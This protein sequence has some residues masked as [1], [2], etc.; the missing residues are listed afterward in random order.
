VVQPLLAATVLSMVLS[1]VLIRH[2]RRITRAL[3]GESGPPQS[4]AMR[5]TRAA[6]AV[7]GRDHVVICGFGRVG[8]NIARVLETTGF[9]FIALE[10]DAYRIRAGRQAGDPVIY[11]DAGE[12]KVLENVGVAHASCVVITFASPE[13]ALRILRAVRELRKDVPERPKWCP[14]PSRPASCC[15]RTCCCC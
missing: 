6:L 7:A 3:L 2:N 11:G 10:V 13:V 5:E 15:C 9:E 12:V 14:K 4:E 8:Q 1:P